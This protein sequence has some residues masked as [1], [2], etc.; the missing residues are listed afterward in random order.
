[1]LSAERRRR[2]SYDEKVRLVEETLQPGETVCVVA[3]RHGVAH[4]LAVHLASTNAPG[5][6]GRRC[7]ACSYFRR[8]HTCSGLRSRAA[9]H[10]WPSPPAQRGRRA[11]IIE[12]D[13]RAVGQLPGCHEVI[14]SDRPA[15]LE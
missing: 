2:R 4:S 5:A 15:S 12:I 11:G 13:L 10:N 1:M 6:S 7:S 3:R 9:H 14:R 8:D